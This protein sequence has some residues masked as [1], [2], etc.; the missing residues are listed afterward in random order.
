LPA[1]E[2]GRDGTD[3]A[4]ATAWAQTGGGNFQKQKFGGASQNFAMDDM[5]FNEDFYKEK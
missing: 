5:I 4:A 1:A 3:S 2:T